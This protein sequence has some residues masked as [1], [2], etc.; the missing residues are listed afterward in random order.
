MNRREAAAACYQ[1]LSGAHTHPYHQAINVAATSAPLAR[2]IKRRSSAPI[3]LL[4]T[5]AEEG[6]RVEPPTESILSTGGRGVYHETVDSPTPGQPR[7]SSA[8]D[9]GA[10]HYGAHHR[11]PR[12]HS[13]YLELISPGSADRASRLVEPL[14]KIKSLF[15]ESSGSLRSRRRARP[16][17]TCHRRDMI[18]RHAS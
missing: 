16:P 13:G 2:L 15:G 5:M 9:D 4:P 18:Y 1:G 6:G 8:D 11:S 14:R 12:A 3:S 7:S 17:D 10:A